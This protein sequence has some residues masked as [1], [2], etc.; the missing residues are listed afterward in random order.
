MTQFLS[1]LLPG[2]PYGCAY[3]LM[4]AGLVLT[5][6]ASGVFNL[7]FG[8]QA[9]VSAVLF[10]IAVNDGWPVWAAFVVA[11]LLAAPAIGLLME[12]LL[13]RYTRT[14]GPLVRLVPVLGL[15][16]AIPSITQMAIGTAPRLPAA[17][18]LE[19]FHVYFHLAGTAVSGEEL[20]TTVITVVVVGALALLLRSSGIGLRMRA[21]VESPRMAELTGVRADRTSASAWALSSLFAGLAGVLLAPIY[22]QLASSDYTALLVAAIAAAAVGG[23]ESLPLTLLGGIGL[24][25]VQEI[26]GGYLP[27]GTILS[28]GL[29]PAFPFVVLAV[30]LV[31]RRTLRQGSAGDPLASCDPPTTAFRPPKRMTEVAVGSRVFSVLAAGLLVA[32]A[33]ALVP[34]NWE[35]VFTFGIVLSII[36]LSI[37]L[38]TGMGG[39]ISLCQA[40]FAGAGAFTAGQLAMHFGTSVLLGTLV[41]GVLAGALGAVVA[42]PTLRLGGI[43]VGLL[44]LSFALLADNVL[45]LY[46]WAGN[47]ATGLTVPRPI[48]G[49]I[50]FAGNGAFFWLVLAVLAVLAGGVKLLQGGTLGQELA[51]LRGSERGSVAIG[52]DVRRLRVVAFMLSAAIAGIGGALYAS[53]E[54]SVSPNDFNYQFSLVY[55]VVVAAV[56]VYSVA[57][58]IEAGVLYAVL[59]QL[60]STLSS[61]YSSLL[62]VVFGLA[63]LTYVRHSEGVV[64]YGK[65]WV[66][67]RAEQVARR[68][69]QAEVRVPVAS[70]PE[71]GAGGRATTEG[72]RQPGGPGP[73]GVAPGEAARPGGRRHR[74]DH[75]V[76]GHHRRR[77]GGG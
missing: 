11:V 31:A 39:Q 58:A 75:A 26:I 61:R 27:S 51:A 45:F 40:A 22:A 7:A 72:E 29:R 12:R 5:Y 32:V 9:Y 8:A 19:P 4:A 62:A 70:G 57:G 25:V 69:Q 15:L 20:S 21:V 41:G 53:L 60:V 17:L 48:L 10:S 3:A 36:F 46:P 68:L 54:Q 24:G 52:I 6:R 34:G 44:T 56:G 43:A 18:V 59:M 23:F 37:T 14:A 73:E 65:A 35:F 2:I 76:G 42:L 55:V 77:D 66:L 33:L 50:S 64:A 71:A 74:P 13:F 38:L 47:G 30:V 67:D 49:S 1:Y 28:S 63:A 16:I